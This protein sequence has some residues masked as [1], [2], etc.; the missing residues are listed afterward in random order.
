MSITDSSI[1]LTQGQEAYKWPTQYTFLTEPAIVLQRTLGNPR[2]YVKV[3]PVQDEIYWAFLKN[4]V[5]SF[6][7]HY[8]KE[9]QDRKNYN[10]LLRPNP[11]VTGLQLLIVGQTEPP[12]FVQAT[13]SSVF[14]EEKTDLAFARYVAAQIQK[15]RNNSGRAV[16][17][18]DEMEDMLPDSVYSP[19]PRP[20]NI[21]PWIT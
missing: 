18:I 4:V 13:D 12:K 15:K 20:N 17:L 19:T 9:S 21:V 11:N 5:Q 1:T 8:K 2:N 6:P 10:L 14:R 7:S 16:E 3:W